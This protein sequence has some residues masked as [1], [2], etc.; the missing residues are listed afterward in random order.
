MDTFDQ[1][2]SISLV[3][4]L[5]ALGLALAVGHVNDQRAERQDNAAPVEAKLNANTRG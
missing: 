1:R 2:R 4:G 3:F 5:V